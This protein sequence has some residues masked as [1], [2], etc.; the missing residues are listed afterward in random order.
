MGRASL[1]GFLGILAIY[2]I[3]AVLSM[4]VLP[5]SQLAALENP[6][7]AGILEACVGPWGAWIV[8]IGVILSLAGALLGWTILAADCPYSAAQQGVFTRAFARANDKGSP[9]FSLFL[10]NG[11]VQFFLIVSYFSDSA[12]QV[13]YYMSATMIMVPYLLSALYYLK[14]V[15]QASRA[16]IPQSPLSWLFAIVGTAYGFWMLY[17][18]GVDQ[19]LISTVLYLPGIA[20]FAIGKRERGEKIFS[21]SYELF[22]AVALAV[23]A[24]LYVVRLL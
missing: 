23:L 3:V 15:V 11:I 24:I 14:V 8:N 18:S 21:Y 2:V 6:Q 5:A 22:L 16:G 20:V 17:A 7:M 10:T 9:T 19:L 1:T 12:Y 13:F 4:G